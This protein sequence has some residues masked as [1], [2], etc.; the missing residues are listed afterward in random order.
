RVELRLH[1]RTIS[2]PG[3]CAEALDTVARGWPV[4]AGALPGLDTADGLVLIRRLLR[5]AVVVPA[6]P[7]TTGTTQ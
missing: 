4:H 5:E 3:Y 7:P 2:F 1:G 6:E